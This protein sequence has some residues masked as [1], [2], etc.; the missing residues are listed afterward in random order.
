MKAGLNKTIP[1]RKDFYYMRGDCFEKDPRNDTGG[2]LSDMISGH[3][4]HDTH[5]MRFDGTLQ[6][7]IAHP[8]VMHCALP[9]RLYSVI[10]SEAKQSFSHKQP[11][12]QECKSGD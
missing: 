6:A 10:A 7:V 11:L 8:V 3:S 2:G 5:S 4:R 12:H 9:L 1:A